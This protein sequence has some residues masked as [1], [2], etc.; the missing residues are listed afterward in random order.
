MILGLV[1]VIGLKAQSPRYNGSWLLTNANGSLGNPLL[2]YRTAGSG[3]RATAGLSGGSVSVV[4]IQSGGSGYLVPPAV[5]FTGGN[6]SG[7]TAVATINASGVVD[8]ITVTNGGSG[9]TGT[10]VV[11]IAPVPGGVGATGIFNTDINANRI[12]TLDGDRTFGRMILG[13]LSSTQIYTFNSGTGG[14]FIF[15]NG[16]FAGGNA[17]FNKFQGGADVINAPVTLNSD[18][19]VRITTSRVT[20]TNT[21]SGVGR[22]N[23]TGNGVLALTGDNTGTG[24]SL[25]LWNRGTN[26]VATPQ[27]EL[28]ATTGNAVSGDII[29]GNATRGTAGHAVLQLLQG[30]SNLDQI[31]DTSSIIFDSMNG[32]GRNAYFKLMGGNE[33]VGRILDLGDRAIIEN[34]ESESVGTAAILTIAGDLDSR[35]NGFV[36]DN[37]GTNL[38]QADANGAVSGGARLGITKEGLGNLTFIGNN[39]IYTGNTLVSEG[40]LTLQNTN[41]FRSN[42]TNNAHLAFE[43]T[44]THNMRKTFPTIPGS[45]PAQS[46]TDQYLSISGSG[47][48]SKSGN[49]TLGI[50]GTQNIG[51]SFAVSNGTLNLNASAAGISIGNGLH[52]VGDST[53]NRNLNLRGNITITGDLVATGRFNNTGSTVRI[54]GAVLGLGDQEPGTWV[55]A[56]TSVSGSIHI[57]HA[58]LILESDYSINKTS[59][60]ATSGSSSVTIT[61]SADLVVGMRVSGNG[62]PAGVTVSA[63]NPVTRVVTLSGNASIPSGTVLT[64]SYSN[65]TDGRI[66]GSPTD[67]TIS[68]RP[69]AMLGA[70]SGSALILS[71][72]HLS[73]NTNR[74]PD[75]T[76]IIS[77]GG[78]MEF[79]N[80][81]SAASFSE[82]A[83]NLVL[84]HGA[85]QL[86]GYRAAAGRTSTLTFDALVRNPGAVIEFGARQEGLSALQTNTLGT[87]TRNRIMFNSAPALTGGI[88]GGWAYANNEWVTYGANGVTPLTTYNTS[89]QD[90]GGAWVAGNNIKLVANQT[91]NA[92]RTINSLNIQPDTDAAAAG[93]TLTLNQQRLDIVT[94]GLLSNHGNHTINS[95][96]NG[97][98]TAGTDALG[99]RELITIVGTSANTATL[100][101]LTFN[102]GIRDYTFARNVN[103]TSGSDVMTIQSDGTGGLAVDML[104]AGTGIP[105]GTR[106]I[107]IINGTQVRLSN[108]ATATVS[109]SSRDFTAGSVGLVKAGQGSLRLNNL[110][111]TYTGP[112][113]VSNGTLMVAGTGALG[114]LP[115]AFNA[116]HFR[117]D[118]GILQFARRTDVGVTN[119]APDNVFE[120]T[121]GLRGFTIG[122]AGGRL[123]AGI[124]NPNNNPA[125][126][127]AAEPVVHVTITNPIYAEGVL[128]LAPRANTGVGQFNTITLGTPAST[129]TFLSGIKSEGGFPG[130]INIHGNNTIGGLV[131]EG[132]DMFLTGAN[133]FTDGIRLLSGTLRVTGANTFQGGQSFPTVTMTAG[134]LKLLHDSALGTEGIKV[135]LGNSGQLHLQGTNQ[136]VVELSG[137]VSS[138][139]ANEGATPSTL[140]LELSHNQTFAGRLDDGAAGGLLNLTK[141]GP[142]RLVLTNAFSNFSGKVRIEDGVVDVFTMPFAGF[143]S[144]L[145]TGGLGEASNLVLAGGALSFSP[146][147]Q[148]FTDRSFT[149]GAGP[150]AGTLVANGVTRAARVIL[151]ANFEAFGALVAS[152]A[153]GFEG[154]G[155]RTLTLGG[156]NTGLNTLALQLGDK[157]ALEPSSI[158]K[159]GS[160][161]WL[162]GKASDY[163]GQTTI[164][165]G[166]L[167]LEANYAAGTT[168]IPTTASAATDTFTGNLPNGVELTFPRFNLTNLPSGIQPGV[169]YY[170]VQSNSVAGTFKVS[171]TPGGAP[172]DLLSNGAN[173]S[174]VP[175]I[176]PVASTSVNPDTDRIT[177]NL[178]NGTPV[179]FGTRMVWGVSGLD[180]P[181]LPGG[182]MSGATYYVINSNGTSFQ[183][184]ATPGGTTPLNITSAGNHV[185]YTA[186]TV[187][188][189][190]EGIYVMGGRLDFGNVDYTAPET[191]YLNGGGIGVPRGT[192][193]SW[194]GNIQSE[195]NSTWTIGEG[196]SLTLTGNLLGNRT[197]TQLGEGTIIFK[198][199]SIGI[200]SQPSGSNNPDVR[201]DVMDNNRGSY[202]LQA[203][204]LVLD[205]SVNNNSKLTDNAT[206]VMGG[207]RRGGIL[208]LRGGNHEEVVSILNLQAGASKIFRDSGNSVIRLNNITRQAGA[209]L[210]FDGAGIAKVD[211]PNFNGILGGWA[212]IRDARVDAYVIIPGTVSRSFFMDAVAGVLMV[213]DEEP[214]HYFAAGVPVRFSS[215]GELPQG[216]LPNTTYYVLDP[217]ARGFR[218]SLTPF[219][220]PVQVLSPGTGDHTVETYAP[221]HSA[222]PDHPVAYSTVRRPGPASLVFKANPA[223]FPGGSGNET[224]R[225]Q[226]TNVGGAGAITSTLGGSGTIASPWRYLI[227]TTNAFNSAYDIEDFVSTD[228]KIFHLI[229]MFKTGPNPPAAGADVTPDTGSYTPVLFGG[230]TNDNGSQTLSWARNATA[231]PGSFNDGPVEAILSYSPNWGVNQNTDVAG[232][233]APIS[234]VDGSTTYTLRFASALPATLN[235][236]PGLNGHTLQTGAILVSPT[237]G[238]NDSILTGGSVLKTENEGNLQNFVFHQYNEL[239]DLVIDVPLV[240][241]ESFTRGA[242][243]SSGSLSILTG[244][245][246]VNGTGD[247]SQLT[248][249]MT[250]TGPGIPTGTTV[251]VAEIIDARTVRL[252]ANLTTSGTGSVGE[253]TRNNY[254]FGGGILMVGSA[255]ITQQSRITGVMNAQGQLAT[256]DLHIGMGVRGIGIPPGATVAS[257]VNDSDITLNVNHAFNGLVT[258]LTFTPVVGIEKL[259]V[260]TMIFN[261]DNSYNGSTFIGDGVLRA[262][263]LTDGGVPGSLGASTNAN[264]NLVF[265]GGTLQYIGSSSS[266]NRNL[267]LSEYAEVSIGHE[268]TTS[269]FTGNISG[270]DI[271]AKSGSGTLEMR[272][273]ANLAEI[274]V[275]EGRLRVQGVD[276]N[277][278]PATYAQNNFG[279]SGIGELRLAGGTFELRGAPEGN[280][281]LTLG[282]QFYVDPGA[283]EVRAVGVP[284]F[285]PN[286]LASG[287][288]PRTTQLSLMGGEEVTSVRRLVGGTV[289]FIEDPQIGGSVANILL[290]IQD[291]DRGRILPWAVYQDTTNT[292]QPGINN[293]ATVS[294]LNGAVISADSA[295]IYDIGSFFMNADNWGTQEAASTIDASEGGQV[296]V[297][298]EAGVDATAG[299]NVLVVSEVL[300]SDFNLLIPD[301]RVFGPGIPS[302]TKVEA[303]LTSPLRVV[304]SKNVTSSHAGATYTFTRPRA[305]FGSLTGD[306][307]LNTL[308]YFSPVDSSIMVPAGRSLQ[309]LSGAILAAANVRGGQKEIVGEGSIS[310]A[311]GAENGSDLVIHNHNPVAPFHLGV[312]VVDNVLNL[313]GSGKTTVGNNVLEV[314]ASGVLTLS[315]IK[316]GML[317]TGPGIP[318]GTTVVAVDLD[319]WLIFMSAPATSTV[320]GGSF[321]FRDV[322]SLVQSGTG[323]TRLSGSNTYTGKTYVHGGVLRLDSANAVPG[324]IGQS[325]GTSGIVVK[326]GVLGLGH[327][328]FTR[329]VGS[330]PGQIEFQGSGGFAAYGADRVVNLGGLLAPEVLRFG[331]SGFVTDGS[332]FI[333]GA[334]DATH[335]TI[336]LNPVDLGSFSQ[337]I[338]VNDGPADI[339]G[340]LA[341]G[342]S[343]LGKLVKFGSGTLRLSG[344]SSHAGGI[345]IA[346]GRLVVADVQD[347]LGAGRVVIGVDVTNTT[348]ND[349]T[350]LEIEG[351]VVS[352]SLLVGNVNSRGA[353]W[354]QRG[355]T[356]DSGAMTGTHASSAVINGHPA[357]AYYDATNGDLKYVRAADPRGHSWLPPVTVASRGDVGQFP[358]LSVISG[359]PAISYY[360]A[361]NKLLMYVRSTD[362]SGVF[363]GN[364]VIVDSSPVNAIGVQAD[365][366]AVI[367]GSFVEFDGVVKT[368][369]ARV[370]TDGSLDLAFN[371]TANGDVNAI[372]VQADGKILV[373][374]AFTEIN[375]T[376]RNRL[377]RLNADGTLDTGYNPNVGNNL[378]RGVLI[379]PDGRAVIWGTFTQ[380]SGTGRNRIARINTAG[381][382]DGFNPNANNEVRAVARQP[383]GSLLLGGTFTNVGGSTRNRLARVNSVGALDAD[384]VSNMNG[385]VSALLVLPSGKILAGGT[386][387]VHETT[388][389]RR[390]RLAR[391]NSTGS[392]DQTFVLTANAEVRDLIPLADGKVIAV[393]AFTEFGNTPALSIARLHPEGSAGDLNHEVDTSFNPDAND[394]VN[395]VVQLAGGKLLVG[396]VF[397]NIGGGTRH[398]LAR[399][400]L[401]DGAG[402][403][404]FGRQVIDRGRHSSLTTVRQAANL[405]LEAPAVSFYDVTGTSL[406][407]ARA[408]D[409][410]GN[411]WDPSIVLDSAANVGVGTALRMVNIGGD[412]ITKNTTNN[413]VTISGSA[414]NG[415]PAVAYY[416]ASNGDLKYILAN[417]AAGTDWSA[418]VVIQSA[419]DV[420]SHLSFNVV[421]G[422]PAVAFYDATA[423]A[424]RYVRATNVA[425]VTNNLRNGQ[426]DIITIATNTLA[427]A[428]AW[429]ASVV[430]DN[431][432]ADIGKFPS[433]EVITDET[434]AQGRPAI[435]YYDASPGAGNLKYVRASNVTGSL[436]GAPVTVVSEGDVGQNAGLML[437]DGVPGIAYH[438]ASDGDMKFVH[439]ADATGYSRLALGDGAEWQGDITLDGRLFFDVAAGAL[440]TISG[441]ISGEAGIT[442][443]AGETLLLNNAANHF[444]ATL[445]G[446]AARVESA[447]IIRSGTLAVGVNGALGAATVELGDAT[448]QILTVERATTFSSLTA[449]SG[450]FDPNHNGFF[451]NAGG[452]GA[453]VNVDTTIDGRTYVEADQGT[454]IL[455]KDEREN[456][457]WNGVYQII[458]NSDLQPDGTMNL[459]RAA[460]MDSVAE[461]A[462]GTQVRVLNGTH[463]G[464]S[465]FIASKVAELNA[466]AVHWMRDYADGNAALLASTAG[467]TISNSI[468]V[469]G[470][471]GSGLAVL[472]GMAGVTSGNVT[473]SS[474]VV[475]QNQ[476]AGVR[477]TKTLALQSFTSTGHGITFSGAF[478][479]ANGGNGA[480]QDAMALRKTGSGIATLTSANTFHGGVVVDQGTL[481]VMNTTGSAT[482]SGAVAVNAGAVLGG[483]GFIGGTV[484]LAGTAGNKAV[485]RPGDPASVSAVETLTINAPLTVGANSVVEFAV[486]VGNMTRLV[487]NSVT[488]SGTGQFLVQLLDGYIPALNTVID[489][490]DG[491]ISLPGGANLRDHLILPGQLA[492]DTSQ[493][494]TQGTIRAL[495]ATE[496]VQIAS[497]PVITVP[498]GGSPVNPGAGVTVT[499]SATVSGSAE[500]SFQWQKS[501]VGAGTFVDVGPKVFSSSTQSTFTLTG[502]FEA[503]EADYRLVATNGGGIYTATSNPVTLMVNDPPVITGHPASITVNPGATA[504]FTVVATGP[505]PLL[506]EW[507]RGTTVL[508]GPTEGLSTFEIPNVQKANEANTYNVR[509]TN[510]A[511]SVTGPVQSNFFAL[512]VRNPVAITNFP[513]TIEVSAGEAANITVLH[514]GTGT[515]DLPN[516]GDPAF[517]YLWERDSGG[518]FAA[519]PGAPNGPQLTLPAVS[520][521]EN[522]DQ[523]RVTVSNSFSMDTRTLTMTVSDGPPTFRMQPESRTVLAG[524]PQTL[525][526]DVGGSAVNRTFQW[527]RGKT[528][529]RDG[530]GISGV[531]TPMLQFSSIDLKQAGDYSCDVVNEAGLRTSAVALVVV[532]GAPGTMLPVE[533]GKPITLTVPISAP[534]GVPLTLK[535]QKGG[536]DLPVDLRI[537]A[538]N[539][540]RLVIKPSEDGDSGTYTCR[541]TGP[542][543]LPAHGGQYDVRVF[544]EGPAL[545]LDDFPAAMV[546][547]YFEYQIKVDPDPARAP[548]SYAA[549]PLPSGL[550]L[551]TKT[552]WITGWPRVAVQDMDVEISVGNK[553]NKKVSQIKPLTVSAVPAR[554]QGVFAGWLPRHSALNDFMGGRFDMTV[555][556]TGAFSG[557]VMLGSV[558][559]SFKG[560]LSLDPESVTMPTATVT[561]P[562]KGKPVPPPL[563]LTFTINTAAPPAANANRLASASIGDGTLENTIEFDAWRNIWSRTPPGTADEL[564]GYYTM[565]LLPPVPGA[566]EVDIPE[567]S[568]YAGFT[569]LANGTLKLAGRTGDGQAVTGAQFVGPQGEVLVYQPLYKTKLKGSLLGNVSLTSS[570]PS[571]LSDNKITGELEWNCPPNDAKNHFVYREGF[572]NTVAVTT[573]VVGGHY[574][575]PVAPEL[576]LG[577]VDGADNAVL[578]FD[579][580]GVE[581]SAS[582]PDLDGDAERPGNGWVSVRT[583]NKL[584][585]P[586]AETENI[587]LAKISVVA[588]TGLFKG[589]FTLKDFPATGVGKPDSRKTAFF[590]II[591]DAD[592]GAPGSWQVGTGYYLLRQHPNDVPGTTLKTAP[593]RSGRVTF[594]TADPAP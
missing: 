258:E 350:E 504:A 488:V 499:F 552:G 540:A 80:N 114:S 587:G 394:E 94:G 477:E 433:L 164:V 341:G 156:V 104:V 256:T 386:F 154:D 180:T 428:P 30:R 208:R 32:V 594:E 17:Y 47:S 511:T 186:E 485:L 173:V 137:A 4:N 331:N 27:V 334:H 554:A 267:T 8:S 49:G 74:L 153:I 398:F 7:A 480:T 72:T 199:E 464:Q 591:V 411:A 440:S 500:Y 112:T 246:G 384:F 240:N 375:G 52:A 140:T 203:G 421:N 294:L 409:A 455:V 82:K 146:R 98:V 283:S 133:D 351:G 163:S 526:V 219:G 271:F 392:L 42:I 261:A 88:I 355:S 390:D 241:R 212:I 367:G 210:Y 491:G 484:T 291:L 319:F 348:K 528:R 501:P 93:R 346:D 337:A 160:G 151:G 123:E 496:P 565:A 285:N 549:R 262:Q 295:S 585:T 220:T 176:N 441:Q 356:D 469:N 44:G 429:S 353:D 61:N 288:I 278:A 5:I 539:Q 576:V 107:E 117:V 165:D 20:M 592:D 286:N 505:G 403:A 276:L 473:F 64:F 448:P 189:T 196:A 382:L 125:Q 581:D 33:K 110:G 31:S 134:V 365:G 71:N 280:T 244:L 400:E 388:N 408:S 324:G 102:A 483:T 101:I 343:G 24:L 524:S 320:S 90:A 250:V 547:A 438:D 152:E 266:S 139:F 391:I 373:A 303:L 378:V 316:P 362:I 498:A 462:Y 272:G 116:E 132:A 381:S 465:F 535:W 582:N 201:T 252:S 574:A 297:I 161:V 555:A 426:G 545:A 25:W 366:K 106:I 120:F 590:G 178:A 148:Q 361:T 162:L 437:T 197:I 206:F 187:G 548:T 257:I 573:T 379:E 100:N 138:R 423:K 265:N 51:G 550:R 216:L 184:S 230:G 53:L 174:F 225:I 215:T 564:A 436:W 325:G 147:L 222:P 364:P 416:D 460:Q 135:A 273:N 551:D 23:S 546:G 495:G 281:T 231:T 66:T 169:R 260:G 10:P 300:L 593:I 200:T 79:R 345:E 183:I 129:N 570:I 387:S 510:G 56:T 28:G 360:D 562:R 340:E 376:T 167:R 589:D 126:G 468:D 567:G 479:E 310:G 368:R 575:M 329:A 263:K 588:K 557:R 287:A 569:V 383:D 29:I 311:V 103:L 430:V 77:N 193:A 268:L 92:R 144:S 254:T 321:S 363:W 209:S 543:P 530:A 121:D 157:S 97:F 99:D 406:R 374:G 513:A 113:T 525:A 492:W 22:I 181:S 292:T 344:S 142:G 226:I 432:G 34:R 223:S 553:F 497:Q 108:N 493:F 457:H 393:G 86:V 35:V 330:G 506:Y 358:S 317:V 342:L 128:E 247:T 335:K 354:I 40:T 385:T 338:R 84:N 580:G 410:N 282:G 48:V 9:Y 69:N 62:V 333:L 118:G 12:L 242:R 584:I 158:Q 380:V 248:V 70:A 236:L 413:T 207:G 36:R 227:R 194:A 185:F 534:K 224:L 105:A 73:N 536:E 459:V 315:R 127:V 461:L 389:R 46:Y 195:T 401:A 347:A 3:A 445:P 577:L 456:P 532:V 130:I 563:T 296:E 482:G 179:T 202:T 414:I 318:A 538:D 204:T 420:G 190:S 302:N 449:L 21:I 529:L 58:N 57:S 489:L 124:N 141:T 516:P 301:M 168:S 95:Q 507:R 446:P 558:T 412:L 299:S 405:G 520:P 205:Y 150:D 55:D 14:S 357:I 476:A 322:T 541:V 327:G 269:V 155:P 308:R 515:P 293:F 172:V 509:V 542:G 474:N 115:Q 442:L 67:I 170:V 418:P 309:L 76:P 519:I 467:L 68:G 43:V 45:N 435:A 89:N 323:T 232:G 452:P 472:G 395:A 143:V 450:R 59:S 475:L 159:I 85:L 211:V 579:G 19:L 233:G 402:D 274:R 586:K 239:G 434:T 508:A 13:D 478:S 78:V 463:A 60:G 243:L 277:L 1:P 466:S 228:V 63:I 419:N 486:G 328:D 453:F 217:S 522:E 427:F 517:N 397:S 275:L 11:Y 527:K 359:N 2:Y 533:K 218:V 313:S 494:L 54:A 213:P 192:Q 490:V 425:G 451:G 136:R 264:A 214:I 188:N 255:R 251:T 18:L 544:S 16:I 175:N 191:I 422:F 306:R 514:D 571:E 578:L 512:T 415:T 372:A 122:P 561:I 304:L 407:F 399:L 458:F 38:Q 249:G 270:T 424:L 417:N 111:N 284:G 221:P 109:N 583:G 65:H 234:L 314:S 253:N 523:I 37:N 404:A 370:N 235:L 39:I 531:N 332:S 50:F 198:G 75:N 470:N 6:G 96:A 444:G 339:E 371:A 259:G 289:S 171:A 237:V 91:L 279:Q 149:L 572:G 305:Y 568:G 560:A 377:A 518:G 298:L 447:V 349:V 481:L 26:T 177:G 182:I 145:G 307:S 41:N 81:A 131:L 471:N 503:D 566:V 487:A 245:V 290:N 336:V 439:L 559:Y 83:G 454:L 119:P 502:V 326:S 537:S 431:T 238:A 521:D 443:A 312:N 15:D 229:T 396:G 166:V 352:N 369:L 87:D 556:S